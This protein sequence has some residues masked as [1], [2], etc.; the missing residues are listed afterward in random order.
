MGE[1]ATEVT[2]YQHENS[3]VVG[4]DGSPESRAALIWGAHVAVSRNATLRALT[5]Y[6]EGP[7]PRGSYESAMSI[8]REALAQ[9]A[10]ANLAGLEATAV[11]LPGDPVELLLAESKTASRLVVGYS[12]ADTAD[13][14]QLG[15]VAGAIVS[16]AYCPVAVVPLQH[17]RRLPIRHIVVG[18]DGSQESKYALNLAVR[19]AGRWGAQVSAINAVSVTRA[20]GGLLPGGDMTREILDDTRL[21]LEETVAE[22]LRGDET[23]QVRCYAVEGSAAEIMAE[24]SSSVDLVVVGARGRGGITGLLFGSTSHTLLLGTQSPVLVVPTHATKN[25]H[26]P[27]TNVPWDVPDPSAR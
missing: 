9:E 20:G 10:V 2:M 17:S 25:L 22:V 24:F 18:V 14:D 7:D 5:C 15:V 1:W 23:V 27:D 8:A 11:A 13:I 6:Q 21:G 19:M 16:K 3:V 4:V 12:G 26:V